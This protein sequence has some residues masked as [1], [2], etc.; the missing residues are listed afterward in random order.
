MTA[1]AQYS[2]ELYETIA[3][4][5]LRGGATILDAGSA[6]AAA[7]EPFAANGLMLTRADRAEPLS[8]PDER[9]DAVIS[10]QAY[11]RVDRARALAEAFRVLRSGG[12]IAVWWKRLMASDPVKNAR[13]ELF[14]RFGKAPV[15]DVLTGGF[16]EFYASRFTQQT[17][18]VLPWRA[19]TPVDEYVAGERSQSTVR[20]A[21]G[22]QCDEYIRSLENR[23]REIAGAGS[24]TISPA[25]VQYL[26]LAKKP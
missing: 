17:L 25:Y 1:R 23:V 4:F 7:G 18:R 2:N 12:T 26:Y 19:A 3:Q 9:F 11:H 14:A 16:K 22:A 20:A 15:E 21:L 5:G 6:D 8:F 24:A 13:D 10:A